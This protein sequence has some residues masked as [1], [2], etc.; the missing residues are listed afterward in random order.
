MRKGN[1]ERVTRIHRM[2]ITLLAFYSTTLSSGAVCA[3]SRR[4]PFSRRCLG[5]VCSQKMWSS[6]GPVWETLF[7]VHLLHMYC[8][9]NDPGTHCASKQLYRDGTEEAKLWLVPETCHKYFKKMNRLVHNCL[10]AAFCLWSWDC[11]KF[12]KPLNYIRICLWTSMASRWCGCTSREN[13][14]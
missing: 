4:L 6:G 2:P 8:K 13:K 9:E 11:N 3:K 14:N 5:R 7:C 1:W 10:I 12:Y